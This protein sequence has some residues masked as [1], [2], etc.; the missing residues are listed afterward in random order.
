MRKV[1]FVDVDHALRQACDSGDRM[2]TRPA[3]T[4]VRLGAWERGLFSEPGGWED[5]IEQW[6]FLEPGMFHELSEFCRQPF[7]LQGLKEILH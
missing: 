2:M 7:K 4:D 3:R 6:F 5:S 1:L